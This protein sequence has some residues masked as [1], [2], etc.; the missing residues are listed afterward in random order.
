MLGHLTA[1]W[2]GS[3]LRHLAAVGHVVPSVESGAREGARR[4]LM[5]PCRKIAAELSCRQR[6]ARL[7]GRHA[8]VRLPHRDAFRGVAWVRHRSEA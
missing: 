5:P 7:S 2:Q 1:S 8:I 4:C 6:T 3:F